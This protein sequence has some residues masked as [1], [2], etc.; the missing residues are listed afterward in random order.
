MRDLTLNKHT[1]DIVYKA[2]KA[3]ICSVDGND[4]LTSN[5]INNDI[6]HYNITQSEL[7]SHANM[8]VL[9]KECFVFESTG[10]T[11]NVKPF[12]PALGTALDVPIVDAAIAYDCPFTHETYILIIRNALHIPSMRYNLIPPFIMREGGFKV[13][14]IPKMH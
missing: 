13:N 8:I 5:N 3:D 4:H 10:Q 7:D 9:G 1:Y 12:D 6:N 14:D 2:L 11:C